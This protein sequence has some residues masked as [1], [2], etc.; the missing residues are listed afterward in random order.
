MPLWL[1]SRARSVAARL[2]AAT[3]GVG[4][5]A[6]AGELAPAVDCFRCQTEQ[7]GQ[8]RRRDVASE[9]E[10]ARRRGARHAGADLGTTV[11][12]VLRRRPRARDAAAVFDGLLAERGLSRSTLR[13]ADAFSA[14]LAFGDVA[15]R[16]ARR[17]DG[18]GMLYE[19]GIYGFGGPPRFELGLVRQ[20]SVDGSDEFL[21]FHCDL[22]FAP[23]QE[24]A[25]L[26]QYQEWCFDDDEVALVD[27]GAALAARPEWDVLR[28]ATPM[29]VDIHV[30]ET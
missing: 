25:G 15:F 5:P 16:R 22:L 26:G 11:F 2:L 3:R 19:Y 4:R 12:R 7:V 29:E 23:T 9:N 24:L 30:E 1:P 10:Q 14:W 18:D 27:W 13:P 28:G 6:S 21:Q 8:D 17:R 20:F